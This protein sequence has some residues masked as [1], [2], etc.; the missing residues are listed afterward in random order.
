ME[1][2]SSIS[3]SDLAALE[4]LLN[5]FYA[6]QTSNAR[7][8]EIEQILTHFGNQTNAWHQCLGFLAANRDNHFVSMF[9]LTTLEGIIKRRWIG[10]MGNEKV[11]YVLG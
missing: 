3:A 2:N 11:S 5:E 6:G 9:V 7:K 4:N 1:D 10:M 8:R